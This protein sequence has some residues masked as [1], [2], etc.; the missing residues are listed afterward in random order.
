VVVKKGDMVKV[1][2]TGMLDDGT[3]FDKSKDEEPLE[4]TVGIG[5]IIPGFD[6]AIEGMKLNEEKKITIKAEDAYGSK[7]E[8]LIMKFPRTS[9]PGNFTPEKGTVIELKGQDG[10]TIPA[11]ITEVTQ[12]DIA[13]DLNHPMAGEDLTF[14]IKVVGVG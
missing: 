9:L 6:S 5:Q 7:D 3:V 13:V 1:Q 10:R 2:Y 8:T 11:T 14:D 12:N 4:F